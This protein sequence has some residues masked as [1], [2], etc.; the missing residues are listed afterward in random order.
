MKIDLNNPIYRYM[1]IG[2]MGKGEDGHVLGSGLEYNEAKSLALHYMNTWR[3]VEFRHYIPE[4]EIKMTDVV[5]N[6]IFPSEGKTFIATY[7]SLRRGMQNFRVN[8]SGGGEF[9]GL[10][11]TVDNYDL[12]RYGGAYFP[13]V[14]L[15]ESKSGQPVVVDVFEAPVSGLEGSYDTLEGHRPGSEH[16]FY[17]RTKVEIEMDDGS[18][19]TAWIY[20]IDE[21]QGDDNRVLS[22][23]WCLHNRPDYY[24][25]LPE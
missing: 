8:S 4:Q 24:N 9:V 16:N 13:S 3:F 22:G 21:D 17:D 12:Y 1:L 19:L 14:N 10:G 11:K 5:K 25:E 18:F 20:H 15:A 6:V 23:D 7:G 2:R